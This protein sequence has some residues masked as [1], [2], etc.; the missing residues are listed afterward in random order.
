LPHLPPKEEEYLAAEQQ[1]KQLKI[2]EAEQ[3]FIKVMRLLR[4]PLPS[5]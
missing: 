5:L 1:L 3:E 2:K 4:G